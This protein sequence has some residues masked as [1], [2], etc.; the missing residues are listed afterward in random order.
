MVRER[1]GGFTWYWLEGGE[2]RSREVAGDGTLP[3]AV[4]AELGSRPAKLA[5][6]LASGAPDPAAGGRELR[7]ASPGGGAAALGLLPDGP[8]GRCRGRNAA[9]AAGRCTGA[10]RRRGRS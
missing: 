4:P 7:D 3:S 8:A 5:A 6:D 2:V 1:D 9:G 10:G